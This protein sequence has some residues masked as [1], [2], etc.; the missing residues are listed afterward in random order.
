[1][2]RSDFPAWTAFRSALIMAASLWCLA[3]YSPAASQT[4][5]H[6]A[7]AKGSADPCQSHP[8]DQSKTEG[9]S[10]NGAREEGDGNRR[11]KMASP[12]LERCKG[13]LTPPKTGDEE[14]EKQAPDTGATPVI[15]P[16][17]LPEQPPK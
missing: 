12:D 4:S 5:D 11:P 8:Q 3:V 13:V 16:G 15:P 9:K 17:N 2:R 10:G 6:D 7:D 1:M 14:I